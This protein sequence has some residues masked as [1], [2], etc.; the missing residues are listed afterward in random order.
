MVPM[1]EVTPFQFVN[2]ALLQRWGVNQRL[3]AQSRSPALSRAAGA[4]VCNAP[5]GLRFTP[6]RSQSIGSVREK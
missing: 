2:G 5:R 4:P 1:V 6:I 3:M